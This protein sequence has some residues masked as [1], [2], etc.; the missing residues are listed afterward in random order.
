MH[1]RLL[2]LGICGQ[3]PPLYLLLLLRDDVHRH[4]HIERVV[5]SAADVLLVVLHLTILPVAAAHDPRVD[6]LS[7]QLIRNLVVRGAPLL[8]HLFAHLHAE[9]A[10]ALVATLAAVG[11]LR[12]LL[13]VLAVARAAHHVC[14]SL[15]HG[16]PDAGAIWHVHPHR[17]VCS[18]GLSTCRI[19]GKARS[20]RHGGLLLRICSTECRRRAGLMGG[21]VYNTHF[22]GDVSQPGELNQV[23]Y[24]R[25]RTGG[26]HGQRS[27]GRKL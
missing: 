27:R 16:W 4:Q 7:H 23:L 15:G 12:P 24:C 13:L 2:L 8:L 26:S 11:T 25:R 19:A 1:A 20:C 21:R 6:E 9:V 18:V 17:R 5:D 3:P 10:Q 14:E 22:F